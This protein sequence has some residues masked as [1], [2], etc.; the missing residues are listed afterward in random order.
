MFW[1]VKNAKFLHVP[2]TDSNQP[3]LGLFWAHM[4]E[5]MFSH[6]AAQMYFSDFISGNIYEFR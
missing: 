5:G 2:N 3:D 4:S 6:V 1:I